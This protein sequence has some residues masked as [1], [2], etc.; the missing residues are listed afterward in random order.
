[1]GSANLSG[2]VLFSSVQPERP[3]EALG[4]WRGSWRSVDSVGWGGE[5]ERLAFGVHTWLLQHFLDFKKLQVLPRSVFTIACH[6]CM[7]LY[8]YSRT[9]KHATRALVAGQ[10]DKKLARTGQ[11]SCRC[12]NEYELEM[13]TCSTLLT[14]PEIGRLTGWCVACLSCC[15]EDGSLSLSL[16]LSLKRICTPVCRAAQRTG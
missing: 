13:V 7:C 16:S 4:L 5:A 8:V 2:M 9:N 12:C 14:V 11:H 10:M 3:L 6:A 1:M 15:S